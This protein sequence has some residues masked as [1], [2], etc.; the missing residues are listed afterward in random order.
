MPSDSESFFMNVDTLFK[1]GITCV[2]LLI[3]Y[4]IYNLFAKVKQINNKLDNVINGPDDTSF[5]ELEKNLPE[6]SQ[7]ESKIDTTDLEIPESLDTIQE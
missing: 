6:T 1:V 5:D 2:V 4:F 7:T 3:V